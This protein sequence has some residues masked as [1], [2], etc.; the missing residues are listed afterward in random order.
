MGVDFGPALRRWRDQRR[1]SQL[2]LA[3]AAGVSQRHLSFLETGRSQPSREMVLHLARI[4]DLPLVRRNE[5]LNAAGFAHEFPTASFDGPSMEPVRTTL[6]F[7]L[8]AHHPHPAVVID[9]SW[10]VLLSN[11]AA[12]ALTARLIDPARAPIVDGV[13]NLL[14]LTLHP[15]GLRPHIVNFGQVAAALLDRLDAELALDPDSEALLRL[16]TEVAGY[17]G[18]PSAPSSAPGDTVAVPVHYRTD[19][20]ELRL[21]TT[22]AMVGSALDTTVAGIRIET[23]FP[24]DAASRIALESLT[25]T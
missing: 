8:D 22:I 9:A 12:A 25:A 3:G 16:R 13:V 5:L 2:D 18:L 7:L 23:F 19:T 4:L 15:D 11:S 20:L 1:Y 24:M 10:D 6:Q 21:L 14:R 17:P